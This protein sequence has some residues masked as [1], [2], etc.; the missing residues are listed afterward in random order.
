[1]SV[2]ISCP[3]C[4]YDDCVQSVPA[5]R[6]SGTSTVFGTDYYSGVGVSSLGPVPVMGSS[7]VERTQSSYLAQSLAP[8][9]GF[10]DA[11]R[12]TT[13]AVVLSLPA[14]GYFA[15]GAVLISRPQPDVSTASIVMGTF[16][17]ALFLA[18]PSL[19]RSSPAEWCSGGRRVIPV[20]GYAVS[21]AGV[22]SSCSSVGS[23]SPRERA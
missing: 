7:L 5:I 11:G 2:D 22:V 4:G 1:M 13:L 18:L 10:R 17:L 19:L 3:S 12:L 15:A 21:A 9:P 20:S 23:V 6:A 14:V 16:G 8:E